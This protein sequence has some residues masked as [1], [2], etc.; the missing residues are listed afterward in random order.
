MGKIPAKA[1]YSYFAYNKPCDDTCDLE[2][3]VQSASVHMLDVIV[4]QGLD[5]LP[6]FDS[7]REEEDNEDE[8]D[9]EGKGGS[10]LLDFWDYFKKKDHHSSK[11]EK[12]VVFSKQGVGVV[13]LV[14]PHND[15]KYG[16][17]ESEGSYIIGVYSYANQTFSIFARTVAVG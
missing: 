16:G 6:E 5:E 13:Q 7:E 14:I 2:V 15:P 4:R 12:E 9:L 3:V 10:R 1:S 11:K 17:A 8:E